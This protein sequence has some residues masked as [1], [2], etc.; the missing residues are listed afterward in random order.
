MSTDGR[1]EG[2]TLFLQFLGLKNDK[3]IEKL[4]ISHGPSPEYC[5]C[6]Y[7]M[8][9]KVAYGVQFLFLIKFTV[10]V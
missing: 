10:H 2:F 9:G 1:L 8:I 4:Q 7:R 3:N 6:V 5:M